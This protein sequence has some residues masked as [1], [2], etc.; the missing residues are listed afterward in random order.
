MALVG[1]LKPSTYILA[2]IVF[3]FFIMGTIGIMG[4]LRKSDPTFMSDP[5]SA[6]FNSTFNRYA[7]LT[8]SV[9]SLQNSTQN[10]GTEWGIVGAL[11][12]LIGSAWNSLR[13]LFS[14]LSF[15]NAVFGGLQMFGVPAWVGALA[16]MVVV[17]IIAFAIWSAIFRTDV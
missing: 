16:G 9:E 11:N 15:M 10:S 12:A 3:T 8:S 17:V 14:S 6:A 1:T 4:E 7:D 13:L 2:I 5:Q